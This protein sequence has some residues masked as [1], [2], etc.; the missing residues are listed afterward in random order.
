MKKLAI[1]ATLL[2][3]ALCPVAAQPKDRIRISNEKMNFETMEFDV[4]EKTS[5]FKIEPTGNYYLVESRVLDANGQVTEKE[6]AAVYRV[7]D[8]AQVWQDE[9]KAGG[10]RSYDITK[11]GI[12]QSRFL[13]LNMLDFETG[14][15]KWHKT[16]HWSVGRV[17][18]NLI[19]SPMGTLMKLGGYSIWTGE[20]LWKMDSYTSYGLSYTQ[21]IDSIHDYI[22]GKDLYRINWQTGE[23]QTIDAKAAIKHSEYKSPSFALVEMVQLNDGDEG[24]HYVGHLYNPTSLPDSIRRKK[25]YMM[26][27]PDP[28][29]IGSLCSGVMPHDGKNYFA[30]RNSLKCFDDDMKVLWSVELPAKAGRSDVLIKGDTVYVVNL[31]LGLFGATGN[32]RRMG[33]PWI[34][35]FNAKDGTLLMYNEMV[36]GHHG[37]VQSTI[38]T[39]DKLYMLF[40]DKVI[41]LS[42]ADDKLET[43]FLPVDD[44]S[45]MLYF[46]SNN[47]YYRRT[48]DGYF[49]AIKATKL[50]VPVLTGNGHVIDAR[51]SVASIICAP[52]DK[53]RLRDNYKDIYILSNSKELWCLKG[54]KATLLSDNWQSFSLEENLLTIMS[55]TENKAF[56]INLDKMKK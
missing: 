48:P 30:D 19:C 53:Y 25:R 10:A 47:S 3:S 45:G 15:K 37:Y 32:I 52:E 14:V 34:A 41:S 50:S 16:A 42:F 31:A 51:K 56:V 20:T 22:V 18:D 13:K 38:M 28:N 17:G 2:A 29:R 46:V 21:V 4:P 26:F 8:R 6:R 12:L 49:Q 39:S 7:S 33:N 24:N 55:G 54:D 5:G 27:L 35:S 1:L 44:M 11:A 40:C 23:V 36:D 43:R 9:Y